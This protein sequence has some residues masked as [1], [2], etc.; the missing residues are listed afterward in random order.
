M[1]KRYKCFSKQKRTNCK[2]RRRMDKMDF[3]EIVVVTP[4]SHHA[5]YIMKRLVLYHFILLQHN[6]PFF[7]FLPTL[8]VTKLF[9]PEEGKKVQMFLLQLKK[10]N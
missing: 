8:C 5:I 6:C 7:L 3:V 4:I 9:A 2:E 1:V 10:T